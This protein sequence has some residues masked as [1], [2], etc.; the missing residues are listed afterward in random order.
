MPRDCVAASLE[1]REITIDI[2]MIKVC[3]NSC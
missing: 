1:E 2:V 3:N